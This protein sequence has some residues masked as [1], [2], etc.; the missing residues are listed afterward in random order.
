MLKLGERSAKTRA[1]AFHLERPLD[2]C[3]SLV[4]KTQKLLSRE[5]DVCVK[6]ERNFFVRRVRPASE[7]ESGL[8]TQF[9]KD[10]TVF[11]DLEAKRCFDIDFF[12]PNF[13]PAVGPTKLRSIT[14]FATPDA[15]ISDLWSFMSNLMIDQGLF[16]PSPDDPDLFVIVHVGEQVRKSALASPVPTSPLVPSPKVRKLSAVDAEILLN[17]LPLPPQTEFVDVS[18]VDEPE[19]F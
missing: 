12:E 11:S 6:L 16:A 17:S 14:I 2:G 1:R 18:D 19:T 7:V 9:A 13:P 3:T 10:N 8:V 4:Y 5:S 15:A